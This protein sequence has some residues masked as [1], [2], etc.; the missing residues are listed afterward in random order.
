MRLSSRRSPRERSRTWEKNQRVS[1]RSPGF[2]FST[3]SK[4]RTCESART[5]RARIYVSRSRARGTL[6]RCRAI[7][8]ARERA[9]ALTSPDFANRYAGCEISLPSISYPSSLVLILIE[10]CLKPS[11]PLGN[12]IHPEPPCR[13]YYLSHSLAY[14]HMYTHVSPAIVNDRRDLAEALGR[15]ATRVQHTG[16]MAIT[17][18]Y[19]S[20]IREDPPNIARDV[21]AFPSL[22]KLETTSPTESRFRCPPD[23]VTQRFYKHPWSARNV[24]LFLFLTRTLRLLFRSFSLSS[25][26]PPFLSLARAPC[27]SAIPPRESSSSDL[28]LSSGNDRV[29]SLSLSLWWVTPT[30]R[31]TYGGTVD[32]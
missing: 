23:V 7:E 28:T 32:D 5:W 9:A 22:P 31:S 29:L 21:Q 27:F 13:T 8:R 25:S 19:R 3:T 30:G 11:L 20:R 4:N 17:I 14:T 2:N 6:F 10:P 18:R 15:I 12:E 24:P 16:A 26:R 1:R